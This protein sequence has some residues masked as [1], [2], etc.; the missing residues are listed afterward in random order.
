MS[1]QVV[2]T[3]HE[4]GYK[5]YGQQFIKTWAKHFPKDWKIT[6]YSEK[7]DPIL[8]DRIS[9]IDFNS[10]CIEWENFY[11]FVKE[12]SSQ[13]NQKLDKK[14]INRLKKALRWS[15]KM[16]TVLHA[17]QHSTTRYLIWL[18]ADV[19]AKFPPKKNWIERVL[20]GKCVAGQLEFVKGFPHVETGIIVIDTHHKDINKLIDWIEIGYVERKILD[21]SKPWDG[22]WIGK[23]FVENEALCKKISMMHLGKDDN[24]VA[25]A[26]SNQSLFWLVHK[27]GDHKFNEL[28]SGRSGRTPKTELI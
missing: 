19:I 22:A 6:Y 4:D 3:L 13:L 15:F 16:F 14:K 25:R 18:D 17:L 8:A 21:E 1:V 28:Y 5:L 24:S 12:E 2:T 9:V 11:N 27:V 23:F 26:F 10:T 7:H 20:E